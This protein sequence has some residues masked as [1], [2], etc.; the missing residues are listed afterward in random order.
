MHVYKDFA[1]AA[2]YYIIKM[3]ASQRIINAIKKGNV[4]FLFVRLLFFIVFFPKNIYLAG[5]CPTVSSTVPIILICP[6]H[7]I[8]CF[9]QMYEGELK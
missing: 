7:S 5:M 3:D 4:F 2:S 9:A 8:K 1:A 6:Y